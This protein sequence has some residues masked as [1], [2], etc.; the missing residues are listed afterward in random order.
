AG[1]VQGGCGLGDVLADDGQIADLAVTQAKL[2]MGEPD[3]ARL[4]GTLRLIQGFREEGNPA[5]WLS[6]GHVPAAW[7]PPQGGEAGGVEPLPAGWRSPQGLGRLP[8]IV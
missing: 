5:P 6:A 3:R 8:H 7:A 4:V 1:G 2:I